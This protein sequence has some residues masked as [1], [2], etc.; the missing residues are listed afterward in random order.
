MDLISKFDGNVHTLFDLTVLTPLSDFP[1]AL[2]PITTHLQSFGYG[3]YVLTGCRHLNDGVPDNT[4]RACMLF[5]A[6]NLAAA[7]RVSHCEDDSTAVDWATPELPP[8]THFVPD[9]TGWAYGEVLKAGRGTLMESAVY[10]S[11]G[12]FLFKQLRLRSSKLYYQSRA[13]KN[14][15]LPI[16][17]E[18]A[19][20][21]QK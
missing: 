3:W 11:D 16:A 5:W 12:A 9:A 13:R 21:P 6:S 4:I 10:G 17:I 18:L 14:L 15:E 2:C 7:I 19:G 8:V 20:Q 1:F